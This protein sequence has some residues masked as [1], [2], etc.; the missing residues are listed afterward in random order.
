MRT[1]LRATV[2]LAPLI[3]FGTLAS[4]AWAGAAWLFGGLLMVILAALGR[5]WT[6]WAAAPDWPG[7][8][9]DPLFKRINAA[10]SALWGGIFAVSG[11]ALLMGGGPIWRWVLMPL[12]VRIAAVLPRWWSDRSLTQRLRDADPNPWPSPLQGVAATDIDIDVAV[13]GAGIG[14]LT[15]AALLAQAGQRVA[16]FEHHDKPGGFCHSW[17]GI[18]TDGGTRLAFRFDAGVHDISGWF[19]GGTVREILRRLNLEAVLEWRRMDHSFVDGGE[20]WDAPRGWDAFGDSLAA[21]HPTTAPALRRLLADVRVIFESMYATSKQRGGVPGPPDTVE[22]LKAFAREHPLAVRW[23]PL[24]FSDLLDHHGVVGAAREQLLALSVYVTHDAVTLRVR[25]MVPLLGYF[26][27]GG[28]YPLGGSGALSQAL[29]DSL[30]LDGG[31]LHLSTP[32]SAV[33]L[34][35]DG[36]GVQALRLSDGRRVRCRAVVMNGDAVALQRLL[37]PAG[38]APK[39]LYTDLAAMRPATSMFAV[40]LGVRGDPPDL[41]PIV[42]L[43]DATRGGA[44]EIVLPSSVDAAAAPPGYFTVELMRLVPPADSADWFDDASAFDPE[45]QRRSAAYQARKALTADQMI[46]AAEALIPDLRARTVFRREA[47]PVTFR[48]YGYSTLGAVYGAQGPDGR[49]GPLPRRS[50][51]PGLVFAGAAVRGPG[52]EPA[53]MSGA[54]AADALWPGLLRPLGSRS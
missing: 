8:T 22:G 3:L 46:D 41:P 31:T 14:G 17:E 16:V 47:S 39:V 29:A 12:G 27:Q 45:T 1:M 54:E 10:L 23:M 50:P 43:H 25:D 49:L 13:V 37:E 40:H 38:A 52:V 33:E 5:S 48:R 34:R 28:H 51:V 7:M 36:Q 18:G 6:A 32:V 15:A 24:R 30:V 19:V 9:H 26:L 35:L 20:R 4:S 21:R 11:M 2:F 53:M 44:L 42:H